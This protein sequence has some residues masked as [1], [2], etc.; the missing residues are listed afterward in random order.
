MGPEGREVPFATKRTATK[1]SPFCRQ[2]TDKLAA[3]L[4]YGFFISAAR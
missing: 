2:Q 3:D 1:C 4:R